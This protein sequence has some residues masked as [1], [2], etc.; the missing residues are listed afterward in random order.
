[1]GIIDQVKSNAIYYRAIKISVISIL[2]GLV[3]LL[4]I[5]VGIWLQMDWFR[6]GGMILF[7]IS[8]VIAFVSYLFSLLYVLCFALKKSL[9]SKKM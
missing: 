8:I 3:F 6:A 1:M 5:W 4:L 7:V 9:G 2:C